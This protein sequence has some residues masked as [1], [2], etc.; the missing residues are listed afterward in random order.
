MGKG[1]DKETDIWRNYRIDDDI[2]CNT[3]IWVF[4]IYP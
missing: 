1:R 3:F 2:I 4:D